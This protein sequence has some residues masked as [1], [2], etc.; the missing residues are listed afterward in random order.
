[1]N[2]ELEARLRSWLETSG[3]S[4]ELRVARALQSAGAAV[5]PSFN[6][7]DAASG[8]LRESDVLARFGWVGAEKVPC[9][10]AVVVECKSSAQYP[11]LAFYNDRSHQQP[12]DLNSWFTFAHGPFTT[13][14]E[15]LYDLWKSQPPLDTNQVATHLTA[16]F[17]K[18]EGRDTVH[19]ALRQ[20]LSAATALR[21]D[22]IVHQASRREGLVIMPV[23]VT[24][25][26]LVRCSL[27]D[28]GQIDL[29]D[30][31]L[32]QVWAYTTDGS[33]HRVYVLSEAALSKFAIAVAALTKLAGPVTD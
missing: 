12:S 4:L 27:N 18:P 19:D 9:N 26:P 14:T 8:Q 24:E 10:L 33:R 28:N 29:A 21:E 13:I 2:D 1:M 3:R 20:V 25:A 11:W 22:Y 32:V 15:P 31:N 5:Q 7:L 6:Y 23:V 16:A 17:T 30:A